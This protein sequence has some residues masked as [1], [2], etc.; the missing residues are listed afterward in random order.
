VRS[1]AWKMSTVQFG[2]YV[3]KAT[4]VFFQSELSL[5]LVNLKPVLPGHVLV[6][7]KR[8]VARFKDLSHAEVADLWI[9]TQKIST[10]LESHYKSTSLTL[11]IQDGAGA[12]QSVF[13]V[14][15]HVIPRQPGDFENNDDIYKEL[16]KKE[17][18][19][20]TEEE[21]ASEASV[22]RELFK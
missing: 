14:H 3:V 12:G 17:R 9:S 13:H 8:V 7:P 19:A 5:A 10:A 4:Q 16:D 21:M 2:Q 15:V 6:I 1:L 20:R 18:V 22:Y 11:A